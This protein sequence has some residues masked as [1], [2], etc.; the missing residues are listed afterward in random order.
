M[1]GSAAA[2]C[3]TGLS[4]V[5]VLGGD[6][7][8]VTDGNL[9]LDQMFGAELVW[10][11]AYD[12]DK[13]ET[14]MAETCLRLRS[15]V[16]RRTSGHSATSWRPDK[17]R[18]RGPDR[19]GRL[20]RDRHGAAGWAGR[21]LR[22]SRSCAW[23]GC[24][25]DRRCRRSSPRSSPRR[26]RRGVRSRTVTSS[27]TTRGFGRGYGVPENE[28]PAREAVESS[29]RL[30]GLLL[31]PVYSGKA[32]AALI[33]DRRSRAARRRS[34][35]TRAAFRACFRGP[36][37]QLAARL[38]DSFGRTASALRSARGRTTRTTGVVFVSDCP[39]QRPEFGLCL[40]RPSASA[41]A[42]E[43]SMVEVPRLLGAG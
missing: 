31:D 33:A 6:P 40:S 27:W 37:P 7:P 41:D 18:V 23:C 20:H 22:S 9:L 2:A 12:A 29:A 4:C 28:I 5:V 15:K 17:L 24:R 26:R 25:C 30:E 10:A 13:L 11:G 1:S 35:C 16:A 32:M 34:S 8:E 21:R 3:M 43:R 38:S 36:V 39:R 14:A 19:L 42:V